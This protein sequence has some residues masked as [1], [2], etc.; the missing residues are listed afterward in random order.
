MNNSVNIST[1]GPPVDPDNYDYVFY[2]DGDIS[3]FQ[4]PWTSDTAF[5]PTAVIYGLTF[6]LGILGNIVVVLALL[7]DSKSRNVT[8]YFLVSLAMADIAFLVICVPY[9]TL[10]KLK[11]V[12]AGGSALCKIAGFV[13][14]LTTTAS[15]MNLMAVS[16]ERFVNPIIILLM[17]IC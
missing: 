16:I 4:Q 7:L 17:P 3:T 1:V 8:S 15:V 6:T 10:I 5:W 12:W 14:M 11:K 2:F 9:E 13:E